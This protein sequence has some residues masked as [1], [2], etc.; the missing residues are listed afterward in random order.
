MGLL[1]LLMTIAIPVSIVILLLMI[2][3]IKQNTEMQIEQNKMIIQLLEEKR[4][5]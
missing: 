4:K 5:E 2:H 1:A 3:Q